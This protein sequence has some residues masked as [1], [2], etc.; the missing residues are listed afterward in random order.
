M[1]HLGAPSRNTGGGTIGN[2]RNGRS[3]IAVT[4]E[5]IGITRSVRT[6]YSNRLQEA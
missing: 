4:F 2:L 3:S 6:T 5:C 1:A